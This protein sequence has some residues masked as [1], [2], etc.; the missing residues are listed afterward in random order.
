MVSV[1]I[2]IY[3]VE[4]YIEKCAISLFEQTLKDIE[5]IF[6]DDC[7][8][9]DSIQ[10]LCNVIKKYPE[11]QK[12]VRIISHERNKGL[13]A[14]RNTGLD[15]STGEYVFHCDSDDYVE[16][17]M[18]EQMYNTAKVKD[19]DIVWSDW[20]LSFNK[21]E[22]YMKQPR[23]E[24]AND[25][26]KGI[27]IGV[28]KYNVWN[29]L[30]KKS[31]YN[32]NNIKFPSGHGMGEDMI[33][34]RLFACAKRVAYIP[35][36]FYHYVRLNENAFTKITSEKH[37]QDILYNTNEAVNFLE[38]KNGKALNEEIICFKL[39]VK[40]P[41]LISDNWSMY[42]IWKSLFP[43][44]NAY[45]IRIRHFSFK[46]RMLQYAA[47]KNQLWL[48]WLYYKIVYKFVYGVIYK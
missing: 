27:L 7:S 26:L 46:S 19:A 24:T 32:E 25:A 30:V 44:T 4:K 18:L 13:P 38:R 29:K 40:Y 14:A 1:I 12:Q 9:D 22:R 11:R 3:K 21:N 37:L 23:Y 8:P 16:K 45:I 33:M 47:Y 10:V 31:L 28:M 41:F 34:I 42:K 39:N 35:R 6:V 43:E 36:A 5:Y 48:V 15:Y 20:F 2:P 17:D